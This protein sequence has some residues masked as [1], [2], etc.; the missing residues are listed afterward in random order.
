MT[1][2]HFLQLSSSAGSG[3]FSTTA[4]IHEAA[5]AIQGTSDPRNFLIGTVI[6]E[7]GIFQ[8]ISEGSVGEDIELNDSAR[9]VESSAQSVP[10]TDFR[11]A[12]DDSLFDTNGPAT[13]KVVEYVQH[14]F[15]ASEATPKFKTK[16]EQ[17]F[18]TFNE[19]FSK[20]VQGRLGCFFGWTLAD[21]HHAEIENDMAKSFVIV[22]G[23]ES[24][25]AFEKALEREA[26]RSSIGILLAWKAPY[27]M[28][29]SKFSL[30]GR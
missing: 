4:G 24:M 2:A 5:Q 19:G 13:G 11:V 8:V 22:V 18:L 16:I 26:F 30:S 7:S 20:G 10:N 17:D 9:A 21:V 25:E 15:S 28:V 14:F 3:S 29:C 27:K 12:F 1:I 23:W 6:Q